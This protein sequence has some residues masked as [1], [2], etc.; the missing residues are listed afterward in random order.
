MMHVKRAKYLNLT[1][2]GWHNAFRH[3]A[4]FV[5]FIPTDRCNL[6]CQYCFQKSR[7]P[8][9]MTLEEFEAY[10]D[11]AKRLRIG[12]ASFLGGEPLVWPHIHEALAYCTER[13]VMTDLTTNGT[14]LDGEMIDGLGRAGLDLLNISV[15]VSSANEV[16]AKKSILQPDTL[17]ALL[18]AKKDHKMAVRV[19][20]VLYKDNTE[21]VRELVEYTHEH[22]LPISIGFVV[23]HLD[24]TAASENPETK[25]GEDI[26]FSLEDKALL[27]DIIQFLVAKKTSG[28]QI[29][30]TREYFKNIYQYLRGEDF[31]NCN[32]E[33]RYGWLNV[34]PS[35]KI[36]SCTK[37][38]DE[39][40]ISFLDLTPS[41]I[42]ELRK[43]FAR[44]I[45]ECNVTCYSNCA[46][47]GYYFFRNLPLVA[48]KYLTG[49]SRATHSLEP[50]CASRG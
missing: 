4:P 28:Y 21:Q 19:N 44:R 15:D 12:M 9:V 24:G 29:I 33:R 32:Y 31:W 25:Q 8:R 46:Y 36:R 10:L 14:L 3:T 27:D 6:S 23:P 35:G 7:N 2:A 20:S 37:K 13:N 39:L 42:K 40:D 16:S 34:T 26:Y 30:D 18:E 5:R 47:N 48:L 45:A 1:R 22:G 38:M 41:K 49:F 43:D 50:G 11:K 17:A